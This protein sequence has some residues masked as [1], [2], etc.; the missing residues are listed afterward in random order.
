M[1][2]FK[3]SLLALLALPILGAFAAEEAPPVS[4]RLKSRA[5]ISFCL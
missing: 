2:Y 4:S 1:V 5:A 3:S